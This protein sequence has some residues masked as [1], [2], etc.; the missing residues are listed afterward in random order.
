MNNQEEQEKEEQHPQPQRKRSLAPS[1]LATELVRRNAPGVDEGYAQS[2]QARMAEFWA[3]K[4]QTLK[5]PFDG[6]MDVDTD[7]DTVVSGFVEC[8]SMTGKESDL[9]LR[10][11]YNGNIKNQQAQ[12]Q[13]I[14][15]YDRHENYSPLSNNVIADILS[16][17]KPES[18][19]AQAWINAHKASEAAI[20]IEKVH[21]REGVGLR[22]QVISLRVKTKDAPKEAGGFEEEGRE[23]SSEVLPKKEDVHM[24]GP[25]RPGTAYADLDEEVKQIIKVFSASARLQKVMC[26][27]ED[28]FGQ[29]RRIIHAFR[30]GNNGAREL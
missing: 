12:T 1:P 8:G 18:L 14:P 26:D 30:R 3:A 6:D 5:E 10:A 19:K 21:L 20:E 2:Y 13:T 7:D 25:N 17:C 9:P 28:P 11:A 24:A 22:K 23:V 4:A 29:R 16:Q 27:D 15:K